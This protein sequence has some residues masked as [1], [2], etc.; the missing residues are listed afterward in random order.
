MPVLTEFEICQSSL[1]TRIVFI[2]HLIP[3]VHRNE[4]KE[5]T[6]EEKLQTYQETGVWP[7]LK[8][9]Q[10]RKPTIPWADSKQKKIDRKE[11]RQKRKEIRKQKVEEGVVK[12]RKRKNEMSQADLDELLKDVN[13]LKKH[14][15]KKVCALVFS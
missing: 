6:R 14:K 7:G 8:K 2:F 5:K 15:K 11:R 9:K 12:K 3:D 1:S 10:R 4:G 13:L